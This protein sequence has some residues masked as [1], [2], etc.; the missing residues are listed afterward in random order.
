MVVLLL[1]VVMAE[2]VMVVVAMVCHN[3]DLCYVRYLMIGFAG[4]PRISEEPTIALDSR[5]RFGCGV[6]EQ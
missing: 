3:A 1:A 4:V 5:L 2:V 6:K